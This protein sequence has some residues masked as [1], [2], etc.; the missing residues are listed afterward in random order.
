MLAWLQM[1]T[2][3]T[4]TESGDAEMYRL[5]EILQVERREVILEFRWEY[6]F[7]KVGNI[8]TDSNFLDQ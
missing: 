5:C 7:G 2:K 6:K 1:G 4:Q 8:F 3:R